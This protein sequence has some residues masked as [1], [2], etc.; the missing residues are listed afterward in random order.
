[1]F[2]IL[3]MLLIFVADIFKSRRRLQAGNLFLRHQLSV[4]RLRI[5]FSNKKPSSRNT[6]KITERN[7]TMGVGGPKP[8]HY[9]IQAI[10][11]PDRH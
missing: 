5:Y 1:M 8:S 4:S 10:N 7:N 6:T 9:K 2:T 3:H 11:K